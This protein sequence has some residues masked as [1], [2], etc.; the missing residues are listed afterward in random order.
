M[1]VD[2]LI[3]R[4]ADCCTC[5]LDEHACGWTM[6]Y[7]LVCTA[8]RGVATIHSTHQAMWLNGGLLLLL[9]CAAGD[10]HQQ[11]WVHHL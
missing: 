5:V 3:G 8:D 1:S 10:G 9:L 7:A 11:G 4:Y 6:A 2:R